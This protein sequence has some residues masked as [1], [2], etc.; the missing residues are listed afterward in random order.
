MKSLS[1]GLALCIALAAA[2]TLSAHHS[3]ASFERDQTVTVEGRIDK[4]SFVNPHVLLTIQSTSET[5]TVEWLAVQALERAGITNAVLKTGDHIV[6]SGS[7]KK[8]PTDHTI[9]LVKEVRR[10]SD[11]WHWSQTPAAAPAASLK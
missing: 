10:P 8:D 6:V 3:Y 11:G 1:T 2:G 4:V 5:Y 9:S 7:P